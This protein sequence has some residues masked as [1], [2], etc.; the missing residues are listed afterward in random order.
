M[1]E[2]RS[3]SLRSGSPGVRSPRSGCWGQVPATGTGPRP[4]HPPGLGPGS[5][6]PLPSRSGSHGHRSRGQ[7]QARVAPGP[8]GVHWVRSFLPNSLQRNGS[9]KFQKKKKFRKFTE[10]LKINSSARA[11]VAARP[12]LRSTGTGPC[13]WPRV[14]RHRSAGVGLRL[15]PRTR[16]PHALAVPRP[17]A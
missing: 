5:G 15:W 11:R 14:R 16:W 4:G 9:H 13:P 3:R 8:P 6:G 17:A 7:V 1:S 10:I 12:W 2:V